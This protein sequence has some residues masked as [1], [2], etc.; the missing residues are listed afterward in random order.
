MPTQH[1]DGTLWILYSIAESPT[2]NY[3]Y[4][5]ESTALF[6]ACERKAEGLAR[7]GNTRPEKGG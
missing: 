6:E 7:S 1:R 3:G 4:A 2:C 5:K